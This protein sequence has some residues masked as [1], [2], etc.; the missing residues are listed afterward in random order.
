[1]LSKVTESLRGIDEN[2]GCLS[3]DFG[4]SGTLVCTGEQLEKANLMSA[5]LRK[6]AVPVLFGTFF[7]LELPC[8]E[9]LW[10]N[11]LPLVQLDRPDRIE[12][13]INNPSDIRKAHI[14]VIWEI[15]YG[16]ANNVAFDVAEDK[17]GFMSCG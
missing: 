8:S 12:N 9:V 10:W 3:K 14:W 17:Y 2:V 7:A 1:M 15:G 16:L 6:L 13:S 5:P 11:Y 4:L